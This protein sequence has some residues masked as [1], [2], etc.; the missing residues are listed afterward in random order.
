MLKSFILPC[1][2]FCPYRFPVIF[3][4]NLGLAHLCV[5]HVYAHAFDAAGLRNASAT[6]TIITFFVCVT[7]SNFL[8]MLAFRSSSVMRWY[9]SVSTPEINII[10]QNTEIIPFKVNGAV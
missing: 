9:I 7:V 1:V 8:G 6:E 4:V 5:L 3:S 10:R 2:S